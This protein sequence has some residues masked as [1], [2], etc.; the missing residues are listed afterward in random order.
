MPTVPLRE[1][2]ATTGVVVTSIPTGSS[3]S[4]SPTCWRFG[5]GTSAIET[6]QNLRTSTPSRSRAANCSDCFA[7][8]CPQR[9]VV[10]LL[11]AIA[12]SA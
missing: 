12:E 1:A 10:G 2:N 11:A 7:M 4:V 9:I 3:L 6:S 8:I 5:P